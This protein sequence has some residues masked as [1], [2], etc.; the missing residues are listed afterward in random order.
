MKATQAFLKLGFV[1]L[2]TAFLLSRPSKAVAAGYYEC[3]SGVSACMQSAQEW[4]SACIGNCPHQGNDEEECYGFVELD[5]VNGEC[6]PQWVEI[7]GNWYYVTYYANPNQVC[8]DEP[9][10]GFTCVQNCASQMTTMVNNCYTQYC[11]AD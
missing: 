7:D 8:W 5:C 4:I 1:C 11:V 3:S 9:S 6:N 2:L 10:S